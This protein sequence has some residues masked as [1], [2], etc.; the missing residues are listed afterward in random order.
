MKRSRVASGKPAPGRSDSWAGGGRRDGLVRCVKRVVV[1]GDFVAGGDVAEGAGFGGGARAGD[2]QGVR[3]GIGSRGVVHENGEI[4]IQDPDARGGVKVSVVAQ[5]TSGGFG[6]L[7]GLFSGEGAIK[8]RSESPDDRTGRDGCDGEEAKAMDGAAVAVG[9]DEQHGGMGGMEPGVGG[10]INVPLT[11]WQ[12]DLW[13]ELKLDET[14]RAAEGCRPKGG[15]TGRPPWEL[16]ER[17]GWVEF[18]R[19]DCTISPVMT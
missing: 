10:G 11:F 15:G 9:V 5:V 8:S 13:S 7:V 3:A 6:E 1:A 18:R 16:S 17:G 19:V 14:G 2:S 12:G 4:A